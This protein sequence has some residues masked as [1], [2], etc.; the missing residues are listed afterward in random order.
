MPRWLLRSMAGFAAAI[1]GLAVAAAQDLPPTNL[2]LIGSPLNSPPWLLIKSFMD[3]VQK[4]SGGK[5][6]IDGR[7]MTE[8]GLMGPDVVRMGKIGVADIVSSS[9]DFAEGEI[10][11][12]GGPDIAGM[13]QSTD[14]L[15]KVIDAWLPY[16]NKVYETRVDQT[17][18]AVWPIGAQVV[19][20]AVPIK[21]IDD[22]KGLKIRTAGVAVASLMKALGAVTVT[23]PFSEVIP[24]LQRKVFDCAVTGSNSG[25]IAH[26]P[27]VTTHLYPLIAAWG[28][29]TIA[30][31]KTVWSKLAPGVRKIIQ[32]QAEA[33]ANE[34]WRV[35]EASFDHG[36]WCTVGDSRCDVHALGPLVTLSKT[37]LT[38]VKPSAED[39]KKRL[40]VVQKSVLPGFAQRCG[41]EC[42]RMWNETVGKAFGVQAAAN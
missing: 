11:E 23:A 35:A 33:T 24:A 30:V 1:G 7:S 12:A 31:N 37:S 39:D 9:L 14:Q 10:P 6:V 21:G 5:I 20:C 19:W 17:I 25:N 28:V 18:L 40:A 22:L 42:T 15:R 8:L 26:W 27:E 16:L 36:V 34:G 2:K 13:I 3:S 32:T 29:N 41:A 38:L 4:D